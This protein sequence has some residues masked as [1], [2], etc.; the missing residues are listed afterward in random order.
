MSLTFSGPFLAIH[1]RHSPIHHTTPLMLLWSRAGWCPTWGQAS[2]FELCVGLQTRLKPILFPNWISELRPQWS[3][4]K[5]RICGSRRSNRTTDLKRSRA[6][7]IA[8]ICDRTCTP[9]CW[10]VW[11]ESRHPRGMRSTAIAEV[12]RIFLLDPPPPPA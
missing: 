9:G 8:I 10:G 2:S 6:L 12:F 11:R 5:G 3:V 1:P 7:R 4:R